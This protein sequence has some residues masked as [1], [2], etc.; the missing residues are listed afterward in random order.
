MIV[1]DAL[2]TSDASYA[3]AG[4]YIQQINQEL[5]TGYSNLQSLK[6]QPQN[7]LY[8]GQSGQDASKSIATSYLQLV[9]VRSLFVNVRCRF[10]LNAHISERCDGGRP[11]SVC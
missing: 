5:N 2:T 3:K 8:G 9:N 6:G 1:L 11:C 4:P 10:Y 7:V